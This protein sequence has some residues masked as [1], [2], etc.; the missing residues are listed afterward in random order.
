MC[1][2]FVINEV[3]KHIALTKVILWSDGCAAQFRCRFVFKLISSDRPDLLIDS[4]Y[5][6][7]HHGKSPMDG[8]GGTIK[9]VVFCQVKSDQIIINS[10][11]DFCKTVNQFCPSITTLFQKS[12]VILS[13]PSDIEEAPII[14][15]TLKIHKFTRCFPTAT[16]ET[17]INF[18]FLLN[19]K[20]PCCTLKKHHQKKMQARRFR[21]SG[22]I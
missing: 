1:I 2:D 12:D 6:G 17:Q 9:N 21:F 16:G 15:G 8:M 7:A 22:A 3:E 18:S 4:H 14:T 11:K 5:N 19:S 13:E 20:E 10:A